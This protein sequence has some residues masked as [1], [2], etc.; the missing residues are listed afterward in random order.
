MIFLCDLK[1][2][3]ANVFN[4]CTNL[5][6]VQIPASVESIGEHAF[7]GTDIR[8]LTIGEN[9]EVIGLEAFR[10][11]DALA[12]LNFADKSVLHTIGQAAFAGCASLKTVEMPDT[13]VVLKNSAFVGCSSL[14]T[15]YVSA[16]LEI[17]EGY[18]FSACP[19]L[20]KF[21]MGEGAKMLGAHAFFTPANNNGF[22]YHN[23]LKEVI[24]PDSERVRCFGRVTWK[25]TLPY[26][27]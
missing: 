19:A 18:V 26:V 2:I 4:G 13:V 12:E 17:M 11:C 23:A 20:A 9:V 22:Y 3:P 15:V 14:T 21:E 5:T 27:K 8:T 24:I 10:D 7:Q 16:S 6:N 25:Y 1:V